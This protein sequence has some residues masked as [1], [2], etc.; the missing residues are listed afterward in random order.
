MRLV[1]SKLIYLQGFDDVSVF[2]L[3]FFYHTFEFYQKK[4][5]NG[6]ET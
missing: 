3:T 1:D 6:K 5:S 2:F 4:S